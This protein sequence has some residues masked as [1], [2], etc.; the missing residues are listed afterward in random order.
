MSEVFYPIEYLDQMLDYEATVT[1]Q[2]EEHLEEHRRFCAA[3][4]EAR[5]N[6]RATIESLT[7]PAAL[8]TYGPGDLIRHHQLCKRRQEALSAT[9]KEQAAANG[10]LIANIEDTL[11]GMCNT[12]NVTS[13]KS[14][15]GTAIRAKTEAYQ[16]QD[17]NKLLAFIAAGETPEEI[18]SRAAMLQAR[19]AK[20]AI[21][22][23]A[24]LNAQQ[25]PPGVAKIATYKTTVRKPSNK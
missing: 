25:L 16:V 12:Q 24:A 5:D 19:P 2:I 7:T 23:Y 9:T 22:A 8:A 4:Y 14:E 17:S 11:Q 3:L 18:T 1:A 10:A 15:Y 6:A 21:E 20:E 13:L